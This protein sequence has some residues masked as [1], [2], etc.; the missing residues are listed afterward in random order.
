MAAFLM[1][2]P[3]ADGLLSARLDR[4]AAALR[5]IEDLRWVRRCARQMASTQGSQLR[6]S[7][8]AAVRLLRC[9][10][11]IVFDHAVPDD[12]GYLGFKD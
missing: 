6:A 7:P 2:G 12:A 5:K 4:S 9:D 3:K 1:C 8:N 11:G 10:S